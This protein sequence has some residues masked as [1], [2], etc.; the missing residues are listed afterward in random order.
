MGFYDGSPNSQNLTELGITYPDNLHELLAVRLRLCDGAS[1]KN[2]PPE[3]LTKLQDLEKKGLL[4]QKDARWKL[5]DRGM[6]FYDTV[7]EVLI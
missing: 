3:T 1:A 4:L 5:T 7:A 2:L 6:L